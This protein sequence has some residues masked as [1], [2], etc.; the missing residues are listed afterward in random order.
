MFYCFKH[1]QHNK[2]TMNHSI[3]KRSP[4]SAGCTGPQAHVEK[5]K[6]LF[7][8]LGADRT[9]LITYDMFEDT[10]IILDLDHS[11]LLLLL[12]W[13]LPKKDRLNFLYSLTIGFRFKTW[14]WIDHQN[15]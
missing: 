3:F 7:S 11:F 2:E 8:R 5:I 6:E 4:F 13:G 9:G 15:M 14:G 10:R 12:L 1:D